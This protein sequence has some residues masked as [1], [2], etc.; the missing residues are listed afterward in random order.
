[1]KRKKIK[2]NKEETVAMFETGWSQSDLAR[3]FGVSIPIVHT[4]LTLNYGTNLINGFKGSQIPEKEVSSLEPPPI[5]IAPRLVRHLRIVKDL[6]NT[7]EQYAA[8]ALQHKVSR[9]RVGQIADAM[10]QAGFELTP[11]LKQKHGTPL[12]RGFKSKSIVT[13]MCE[14]VLD[15]AIELGALQIDK[16]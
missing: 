4:L 12:T 16:P 5:P 6:L 13:Q 14:D 11:R 15:K 8:I 3:H 7:S 1:M 10:Y 2:L 9:E